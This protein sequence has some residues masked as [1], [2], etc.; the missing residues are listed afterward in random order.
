MD[1]VP[2]VPDNTLVEGSVYKK[3]VE[4]RA[5][6]KPVHA[7]DI[8][9]GHADAARIRDYPAASKA[10]HRVSIRDKRTLNAICSRNPAKTPWKLK[11]CTWGIK[12]IVNEYGNATIRKVDLRH[13][14]QQIDNLLQQNREDAPQRSRSMKLHHVEAGGQSGELSNYAHPREKAAR[15]SGMTMNLVARCRNEGAVGL[16]Y[17][18]AS[19]FIESKTKSGADSH[20]LEYSMLESVLLN[21]KEVDPDGIYFLEKK[22]L[23][24]HVDG[25][26]GQ[27]HEFKSWLICPSANRHFWENSRHTCTI[28]GT[29]LTTVFDGVLL[30]V[31]VKDACDELVT[32]MVAQVCKNNP[33]LTY[34]PSVF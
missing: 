13:S 1:R 11:Y 27:S 29:H 19:R 3:P 12:G 6:P 4:L 2:E 7:F 24:Y 15:R 20:M 26:N 28:D 17:H 18:Q 21:L 10:L 23:S 25:S 34:V 8:I 32:V 5:S 30:T 31:T 33:C 16:S 9:L 14:C 22:A